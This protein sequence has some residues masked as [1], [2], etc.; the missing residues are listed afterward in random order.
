L[1]AALANDKPLYLADVG[2]VRHGTRYFAPGQLLRTMLATDHLDPANLESDL[3]LT[4]SYRGLEEG[5]PRSESFPMD[6]RQFAAVALPRNAP[7][8]RLASATEDLARALRRRSAQQS[9]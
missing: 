1:I 3:T 8:R 7:E 4:A 2:I 9:R 6:L 5:A